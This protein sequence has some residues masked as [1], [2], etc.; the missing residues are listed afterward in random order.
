MIP[1]PFHSDNEGTSFPHK[2]ESS[3]VRESRWVPAFAGT[4][5]YLEDLEVE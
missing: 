1:I 4:T 2:R 3:V 5:K